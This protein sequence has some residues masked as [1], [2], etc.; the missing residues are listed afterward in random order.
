[1]AMAEKLLAFLSTKT[2]SHGYYQTKSLNT[3][4]RENK[5]ASHR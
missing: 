5:M 3:L 4:E 1:M 2:Q